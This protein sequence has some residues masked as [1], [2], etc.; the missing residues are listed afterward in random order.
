MTKWKTIAGKFTEEELK[1]IKQF[2]KELNL[3]DNQFV[4]ISILQMMFVFR[5]MLE[6]ADSGIEKEFNRKYGILKKEILKHQPLEKIP[7]L[8]QEMTDTYEQA[9]EQIIKKHEPE[10]KKFTEKRILG[11]PKSQKKNP[12]RPKDTGN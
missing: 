5:T 10:I 6:L 7:S 4:R 12:G 3:N 1:I 9:I 2:Q 8:V 11:R